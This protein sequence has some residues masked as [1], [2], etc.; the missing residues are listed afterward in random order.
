MQWMG[1][2][3]PPTQKPGKF[4]FLAPMLENYFKGK[5]QFNQRQDF[6]NIQAPGFDLG[7]LQS[8]A[9]QRAMGQQALQNRM[10]P[11]AYQQSQIGVNNAR[12]EA[13]RNPP[14]KTPPET[15]NAKKTLLI[16]LDRRFYDSKEKDSLT[17]PE[18][19]DRV[20]KIEQFFRSPAGIQSTPEQIEAF[21]VG[22]EPTPEKKKSLLER[23]ASG[24][25]N[26]GV[27][28]SP[29]SQPP[30]TQSKYK[31]GQPIVGPDGKKYRVLEDSDDPLLEEI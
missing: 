30:N 25:R 14:Q 17:R 9:Y 19:M 28:Q 23:L 1:W 27:I 5:E 2:A 8:N 26:A 22:L 4:D 6:R 16:D 15:E 7:G 10:P 31:K 20:N 29:R 13:L 11:N 24:F 3:P 18:Y 21:Y 12:A